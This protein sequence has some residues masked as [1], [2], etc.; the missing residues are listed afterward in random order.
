[1]LL[2]SH[3]SSLA[4]WDAV[5]TP[6]QKRML[7]RV[8]GLTPSPKP[9]RASFPEHVESAL[10]KGWHVE[11]YTWRRSTSATYRRFAREYGGSGRF[12]IH[13]LDEFR[14]C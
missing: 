7:P 6:E 12:K 13:F 11:L 8:H 3:R 5:L 10:L 2:G 14:L 1:M 4:H 9:G